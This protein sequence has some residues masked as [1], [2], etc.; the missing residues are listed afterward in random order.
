MQLTVKRV[1]QTGFFLLEALV[2]ILIFSLGIL[3]LVA[4]GSLAINAQN[5]AQYRTEAANY[6]SDIAGQIL[7]N[8]DRISVTS[9]AGNTT[10]VNPATL[11]TFSHYGSAPAATGTC[12]FGGAA[13]TNP[14]VTTWVNKITTTSGGSYPLPGAN[15]ANLQIA[16]NQAATGFNQV[17]V[18]VCWKAPSDLAMRQHTLISYIN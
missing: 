8:V 1:H 6:A 7:L 3:G 9:G 17:T 13:S 14:V 10:I 11:A 4:M 5:D 15:A 2:A 18:T 16:I 12:A